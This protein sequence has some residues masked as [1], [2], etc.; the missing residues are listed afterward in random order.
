VTLTKED[1]IAAFESNVER[2]GPVT[3]AL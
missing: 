3:T 1:A 2:S